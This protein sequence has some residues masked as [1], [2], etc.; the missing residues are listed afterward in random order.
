[1]WHIATKSGLSEATCAYVAENKL[2]FNNDITVYI[3]LPVRGRYH[4]QCL[5]CLVCQPFT[6]SSV[7]QETILESSTTTD[8]EHSTLALVAQKQSV[9]WT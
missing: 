2:S 6:G 3:V 1:M 9:H 7:S 8:S 4:L 5:S